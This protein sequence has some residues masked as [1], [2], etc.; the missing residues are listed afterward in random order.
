MKQLSESLANISQRIKDDAERATMARIER[1]AKRR[2]IFKQL[3]EDHKQ[4]LVDVDKAFVDRHNPKTYHRFVGIELS[5]GSK[6]TQ[7]VMSK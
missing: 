5:D 6:Y 7:G 4:H 1:S 3:P 2:A